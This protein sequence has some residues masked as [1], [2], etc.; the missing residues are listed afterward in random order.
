MDKSQATTLFYD[1]P[2]SAWTEALPIGNGRL[3]AMVFGGVEKERIALNEDTLWSG[4][5]RDWNNPGAKEVLPRVRKLIR[6]GRYAEADRL[7][8]EMMGPYTQSYLPFG[9][10]HVR[11]DHGSSFR[12]YKRTLDL[13]N[14]VTTVE[15]TIG[16]VR[17]KREL[18]ASHPDQVIVLRLEASK[19]GM[20]DVHVRLDSPLRHKTAAD[21]GRFVI[22]GIAPEYAA[23]NYYGAEKQLVYGDPETT[24]AIRF[25][26][27]VAAH[28]EDGRVEID[29]DGVHVYESTGAT[30]VFSAATSFNGFDRIPGKDGKNA[31][32]LAAAALER[33]AA[34][35]YGELREA[36]AADY[37]A[38]FGRVGL[39]L[40][41]PAAPADTPTD[42]RIAEYGASDPALVELLFHYGRY[43]MIASS[44]P[45]TQAANLQGIWNEST[46]P[47]WSSNWTL[48]INAEMNY[49]PA[50][51][52][53][54]AECHEPLLRFI[55]NLAK[56]GAV[57]AQ[58]NYGARGWTA[59]HNSD[60]WAQSAPVGEY[61]D[62]DPIWVLWPMG[63]VWLAQHLWEHYAFGGDEAYLREQAY[64]VMKEAALFCLDFPIEDEE[65]RLITSPSTSPEHKFRTADG[66][67]GLSAASTMD[68]SLIWELF[69]NCIA[70]AKQ[71]GIDDS[72]AAELAAARGK[73]FPMQI[74]RHGQL[75]EWSKDFD[76]QDVHHR[77]VSHLFGVYPGKQLTELVTPELFEAAK[78]S[79]IRRGDDGTGWSLGWKISLWARFRSGNRALALVSNLLRLVKDNEP[80]NYHHGGVYGNLFD[81][82][83]PFQIDGNFAATAGI[84]EMLLQSHQPFLELLPALPDSWPEGEASGLRARGGFEV[85]LSWKNGRLQEA[86]ILSVRGE[87]CAVLAPEG[88]AV[89][90]DGVPVETERSAEGAVTFAAAAGRTYRLARQ[91]QA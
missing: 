86:E 30:I 45:G 9:D 72:F 61:G 25:E 32:A 55:G 14:G 23:P 10:L 16:G 35:R 64:P 73:L 17:Y 24:P 19:P 52:C 69:T 36:H 34:K 49:W 18:F 33:A 70:A 78:Q 48:N 50:E 74:G 12:D 40:G 1:R 44:R 83:P 85:K 77:H 39:R 89:T 80:D 20:L 62:G 76:D 58:V 21:G 75:Q 47:P 6:E 7:G 37:R 15:Y 57:T 66:E 68:M 84:A 8:K 71:L 31:G 87:N 51:T 91:S 5:P 56:T 11:F 43:L 82:H 13:E 3:G 67:F 4:Y 22:R 60:I 26:G 2:A 65:G 90:H 54:L 29:A 42:K 27:C 81:A 88:F 38:L 53:N 63:G 59:H 41:K 79:L 46:Q 28:A